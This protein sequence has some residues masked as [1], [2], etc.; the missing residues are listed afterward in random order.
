[1]IELSIET[2]SAGTGLGMPPIDPVKKGGSG[3]YE[4]HFSMFFR[5]VAC[6]RKNSILASQCNNAKRTVIGGRLCYEGAAITAHGRGLC[7]IP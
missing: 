7:S 1:M 3:P 4:C 2:S 6:C 5:F